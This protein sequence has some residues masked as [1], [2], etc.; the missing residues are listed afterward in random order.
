MTATK[1]IVAWEPI[2]PGQTNW[3]LEDVDVGVPGEGEVLVEML[4]TGI[5]HTDIVL[6]SIPSGNLGITYPKVVG[7]EGSG[8]VRSIGPNTSSVMVGDP[9]LLSYHSCGSC[10]KCHESHPAYCENFALENYIGHKNSMSISGTGDVI[11]SRFFG[12]SSLAQY[13]VVSE[14][15]IVNVKGLLHDQDELK[16]FAPLGCGFQTGMGAIWNTSNAGPED[17]V[18][19]LGLGAVG[20]GAL[21]TAKI[22]NCETIIVVDRIEARLQLAKSLGA[23]HTIN[24]GA[25]D[26]TTLREITMSLVSGGVSVVIDTTG[27]PSLIEDSLQCT[28]K[29]GKLILIGVP[30]RGYKLNIDVVEHINAIPQMIKWYRESRFPI[31][32]SVRSFEASQFREAL[33]Q[34][35]E[36]TVIKPVLVWS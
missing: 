3:S 10:K 9:V 12:Q 36:G 7:H 27:A 2:E 14:R 23:S 18:M 24:T 21:M 4:A 22:R 32:Q 8:I 16:L 1:A 19:I 35:K 5:C 25:S 15:S 33:S 31:D 13:S 28:R 26:Y 11:T 6:S 17:A 29:L 20:M 30:P 34:L